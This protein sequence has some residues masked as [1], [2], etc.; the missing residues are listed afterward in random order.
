MRQLEE[1]G[2]EAGGA[3]EFGVE[4]GCQQAAF[5][6]SHGGAVG[7]ARDQS[8][9]ADE[10]PG[11]RFLTFFGYPGDP[12]VFLEVVELAAEGVALDH[13]IAISMDGRGRCQDN[14]FVERPGTIK[15][16]YLDLHSF[17]CLSD[18]SYMGLR[19][20]LLASRRF[21][22]LSARQQDF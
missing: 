17:G 18:E 12:E 4:G 19:F 21:E 14:N 3:G 9:D 6:G 5:A 7:E 11:E 8:R 16:K 22:V 13:E 20:R 2:V 10:N 15:P 1:I